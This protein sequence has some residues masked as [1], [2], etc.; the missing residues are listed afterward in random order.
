LERPEVKPTSLVG[1]LL[2][3]LI[4][5]ALLVPLW[6]A[7]NFAFG[8]ALDGPIGAAIMEPP[9]QRLARTNEPLERYVLGGGKGRYS[10]SV[11]HFA[12]GPV[13][14][15]GKTEGLGFTGRELG[16]LALGFAGYAACFAGALMLAFFIVRLG[17]RWVRR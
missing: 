2:S 9:C 12:S 5:T 17:R 13:R 4:G 3:G 11:C 14:V 8:T 6:A 16:Y 15:D 1:L 7:L 10:S